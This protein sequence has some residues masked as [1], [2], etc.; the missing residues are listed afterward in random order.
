MQNGSVTGCNGMDIEFN[1][2]ASEPVVGYEIIGLLLH[3]S[4][5]GGAMAL[6]RA[7]HHSNSQMSGH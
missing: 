4:P 5:I 1:P 2:S 6:C 3:N 7:P